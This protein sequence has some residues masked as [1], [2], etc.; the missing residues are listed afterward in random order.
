MKKQIPKTLIVIAAMIVLFLIIWI[1]S[2]IQCEVLTSKYHDDFAHA[3]QNNSWI[4]HATR[5]KVL[6]CDGA[7]AEVYYVS[8]EL[9]AVLEFQK[10]GDAWE[11]TSWHAIWAKHGSASSAVWPYWWQVFITGI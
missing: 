4:N 2:L 11:E 10:Q 7:T 5:F 6:R 9:G 1:A 8:D 3:H